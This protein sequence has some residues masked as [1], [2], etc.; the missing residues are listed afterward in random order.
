M[1]FKGIGS[2]NR[3]CQA[4]VNKLQHIVFGID[5]PRRTAAEEF[6]V[7]CTPWRD[8]SAYVGSFGGFGAFRREIGTIGINLGKLW[9]QG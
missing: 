2:A 7:V 9:Q 5:M 3:I 6:N 4:R 1:P 8:I